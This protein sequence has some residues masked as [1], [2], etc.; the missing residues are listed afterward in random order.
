M[1]R[2]NRLMGHMAAP[3]LSVNPVA[4]SRKP[5]VVAITGAAGNIAYSIIFMVAKGEM[6]GF[7]QPIELRL[8]DI[9]GMEKNLQGV[10]MEVVDCAFPLITKIVPTTDYKEAFQ[11]VEIALL[12]GAR[13]R[14]P[15]MQRGD[16]LSANAAIFE[17]QGKALNSYANKHVKVLVVG[18]PANTNA[19][20]AMKNAPNLSRRNF[21]AMTRLDQNRAQAQIAQRL[22]VSINQVTGIVVWGNHSKT[23][24]PS[25]RHAKVA[26][27]GKSSPVRAAVNNDAWLQKEYLE[28]VQDRGAAIIAARKSSSA[29]SAAKAA[30][31]HVR[32]WVLGTPEGTVSSM[33][34][35]SDGNSYGVPADLIYSFPC[36][37]KNGE[38]K[39]VTGLEIDDY[40]RNLMEATAKELIEERTMASAKKA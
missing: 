22:N 1:Q 33:A 28:T 20:I 8:L 7:D 37:C 5:V 23:Q 24:Y 9:P 40:S 26:V 39:I 32:E 34:V 18:N 3:Q 29:A 35:I 16:L 4:A 13:P 30:V 17:G 27:D 14:G 12:I 36:V 11:D 25:I 2:A 19:L 10:V 21:T 15:G 6:L 38:W 31:D